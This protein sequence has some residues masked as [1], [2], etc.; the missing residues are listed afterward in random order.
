MLILVVV[1]KRNTIDAISTLTA[2]VSSVF[3]GILHRT[4]ARPEVLD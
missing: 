1:E 3:L 2:Q 4:Q